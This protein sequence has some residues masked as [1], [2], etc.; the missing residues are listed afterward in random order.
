[1]A[2]FFWLIPRSLSSQDPA[3]AV[4]GDPGDCL[5]RK[6][7]VSGVEGQWVYLGG[8]WC[9][10]L[11]RAGHQELEAVAGH[12]GCAWVPDLTFHWLKT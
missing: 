4:T 5:F 6:L 2:S 7:G 10:L 3:L 1:M 11:Y 9:T 12:W 8:E